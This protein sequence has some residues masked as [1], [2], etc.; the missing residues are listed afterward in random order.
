MKNNYFLKQKHLVKKYA[1]L[2]I[3]QIV[4][5]SSLTEDSWILLSTSAFNLLWNTV[6]EVHEKNLAFQGSI[7]RK[8]KSNLLSL[9]CVWKKIL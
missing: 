1:L 5:M 9:I 8:G 6:S 2:Y 4:F 3:L 7:V